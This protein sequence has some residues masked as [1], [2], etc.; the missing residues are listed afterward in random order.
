MF[1]V[2]ITKLM[3]AFKTSWYTTKKYNTQYFERCIIIIPKATFGAMK[4]VLIEESHWIQ[5]YGFDKSSM[6]DKYLKVVSSVWDEYPLLLLTG[7]LPR[8]CCLPLDLREGGR[9]LR[10]PLGEVSEDELVSSFPPLPTSAANIVLYYYLVCTC[11][12]I[13]FAYVLRCFS[14]LTQAIQHHYSLRSDSKSW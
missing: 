10:P 6:Q 5:K 4:I 1:M 3:A 2:S 13:I 9:A 8:T 11:Q 14:V 12:D 7:R